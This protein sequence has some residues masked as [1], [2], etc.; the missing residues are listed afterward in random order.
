MK[1]VF[2]CQFDCKPH[3]RIFNDSGRALG[4]IELTGLKFKHYKRRTL[5][6]NAEEKLEIQKKLNQLNRVYKDT[7][8]RKSG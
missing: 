7:S 2:T 1:Y 6:I 4:R 3:Y 5:W 8:R